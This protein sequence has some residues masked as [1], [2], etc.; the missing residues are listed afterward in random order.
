MFRF[1]NL[2]IWKKSIEI[3]EKLFDISD[4]L[5]RKKLYKLS[6]FIKET[7][8]IPAFAGMTVSLDE[9]LSHSCGSRNPVLLKAITVKNRSNQFLNIAKRSC[10]ENANMMILFEK[11]E[12]IQNHV[13]QKI[14]SELEDLCRMISGFIKNLRT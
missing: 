14:L 13:K 9:C 8:W 6:D 10:F 7:F 1:E 11:R 4:D 5:E 2:E 3:A 12:Y